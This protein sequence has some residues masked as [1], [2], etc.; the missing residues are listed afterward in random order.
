MENGTGILD[1]EAFVEPPGI[2]LGGDALLQVF[3]YD[4]ADWEITLTGE[5]LDVD[6]TAGTSSIRLVNVSGTY[7]RD[8]EAIVTM[9]PM[10]QQTAAWVLTLLAPVSAQGGTWT[11]G[12]VAPWAA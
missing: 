8:D 10:T 1:C 7:R 9:Q 5:V 11:N 3:Q 4:G 12:D 2:N 6:A